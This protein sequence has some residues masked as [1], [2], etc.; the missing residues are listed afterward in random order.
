LTRSGVMGSWRS[1]RPIAW[2]KALARAA[3]VGGSEPS[4][5]P[6]DGSLRCIRTMSMLGTLMKVRTG[7]QSRLVTWRRSNA[8]CSFSAAFELVLRAVRI[9][10]ESEIGRHHH[11]RHLGDA[12][13]AVDL[14]VDHGA[15]IHPDAVV[16]AK[17]QAAA[18][19]AIAL[20]APRPPRPVGGN[21]EH[22]LR[23]GIP[24][25]WQD[26]TPGDRCRRPRRV[27]P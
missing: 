13:V 18:A 10:H 19:L 23:P 11:A 16:P 7:Y 8:T 3:E 26:G 25:M 12:T 15:R 9:D 22:R 4:P 5:T 6:S 1:R 27:R 17:R 2:A 24:E 21:L 20:L 14:D